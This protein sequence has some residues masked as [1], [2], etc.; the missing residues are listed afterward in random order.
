MF[1]KRV[2]LRKEIKEESLHKIVS[3]LDKKL[4]KNCEIYPKP[5]LNGVYPDLLVMY[6]NFGIHIYEFSDSLPVAHNNLEKIDDVIRSHY[7]SSIG[8]ENKPYPPVIWKN[9]ISNS[10][11]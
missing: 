8:N 11:N 6:P 9:T 5:F 2:Y 7:C 3:Y 10:K 1:S 4:P